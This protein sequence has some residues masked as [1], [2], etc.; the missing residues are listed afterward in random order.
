M[1]GIRF[2]TD[3]DGRKIAVQI[4]LKTHGELWEDFY[5]ALIAEER[6][7]EPAIPYE[8]YRSGR[9]KPEAARD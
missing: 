4:N 9:M 1:T 3:E 2:L 8:E 7:G 5:D 6:R